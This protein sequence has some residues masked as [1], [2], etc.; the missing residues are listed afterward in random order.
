MKFTDTILNPWVI[1]DDHI[2]VDANPWIKVSKQT[3]KLPDGRQ[4]NDYYQVASPSF[5]EIIPVNIAGNI[6]SQWRYKHG[7]KKCNL[8]FPGGYIKDGEIPQNAASRELHEECGLIS[9]RWSYL[10]GY[11]LDGNRSD[12]MAHLYIAWDCADAKDLICSDDLEEIYNVWLTPDEINKSIEDE[13]IMM[14]SSRMAIE[15]ALPKI[16]ANFK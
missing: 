13:L 10:G 2:L 1:L 16:H 4:I 11:Y 5:V 12:M 14:I 7:P 6:L 15:L 9:E 8:A 3:I